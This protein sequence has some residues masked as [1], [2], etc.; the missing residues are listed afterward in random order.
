MVEAGQSVSNFLVGIIVFVEFLY[1]WVVSFGQDSRFN[2][3]LRT[4]CESPSLQRPNL[5]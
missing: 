2:L 1:V 5:M 3:L 4:H